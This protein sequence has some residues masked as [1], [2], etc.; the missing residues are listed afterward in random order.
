[1]EMAGPAQAIA[2]NR[3]GNGTRRHQNWRARRAAQTRR[4]KVLFGFCSRVVCLLTGLVTAPTIA[5]AETIRSESVTQLAAA[6]ENGLQPKQNL[7]TNTLT[8]SGGAFFSFND[9]DMRFDSGT[10]RGTDIDL[11]QDF[12]IQE[13][14]TQPFGEAR[15]RISPRHQ[16]NLAGF[17]LTRGSTATA[18]ESFN[19]GTLDVE[20]GVVLR[21]RL[22]LLLGRITYGYSF[23]NDGRTEFGILIGSHIARLDYEMA[24]A[25]TVA[26]ASDVG[27]T[28]RKKITAPLPHIGFMA[29]R[30]L[31][32]DYYVEGRLVGFYLEFGRLSGWLL[33]GEVQLKKMIWPNFGIG[34]GMR[35]FEVGLDQGNP[36]F[37][38]DWSM[39]GPTAFAVISF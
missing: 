4:V 39:I 25:A 38:I 13:F 10:E 22:N 32:D 15:W 30:A 11:E 28:S 6:H 29:S 19:I 36:T 37:S 17:S 12:G 31:G 16:V 23:L 18:Q 24:I 20:V 8:I 2:L 7:L 35:Y 5:S 33:N 3:R 26:G 21:T 27:S 14:K 34:V 1:M 9:T